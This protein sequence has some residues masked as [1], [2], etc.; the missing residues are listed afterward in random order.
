MFITCRFFAGHE[1]SAVIH[2]YVHAATAYTVSVEAE[3]AF[4][5]SGYSPSVTVVT[6]PLNGD[7]CADAQVIQGTPTTIT[8]DISGAHTAAGF[9]ECPGMLWGPE[10]TPGVW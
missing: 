2:F 3:N 6:L 10:H 9:E 1:T 8:G 4:G 7:A 5:N